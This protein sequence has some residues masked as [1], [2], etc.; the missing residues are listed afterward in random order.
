[1]DL[2][3][4]LTNLYLLVHVIEAGGFSAAA[5]ELGTTRSLLSRH[6]IELEKALGTR[7][8]FRDA[9][10]FSVT[11]TGENVYRQ[12]IQMCDAAHAAIAAANETQA[13]DRGTV[14]VGLQSA[15]APLIDRTLATFSER[16]PEVRLSTDATNQHD[17]LLHQQADVIFKLGHRL[18]DSADIVAHPLGRTRLVIVASPALLQHLAIPAHPGNIQPRHRLVY[19][20]HNLAPEWILRGGNRSMSEAPRMVSERIDPVINAARAGMG[21]VQLPLYACREDLANGRLQVLFQPFEPEPIP[22]HAL[23]LVSNTT[24]KTALTFISFVR[25]A[26]ATHNESDNSVMRSSIDQANSAAS[27]KT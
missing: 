25:D 12:A 26:L 21:L 20:G 7:L 4:H 3:R 15:L 8:L 16:Y 17:A 6:V 27:T 18:P 14:R 24:C 13:S 22:I 5:R 23:T 19:T 9:R 1:M 2:S 10:R 11:P